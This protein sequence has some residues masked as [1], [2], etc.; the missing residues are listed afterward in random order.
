[1]DVPDVRGEGEH[2]VKHDAKDLGG[3]VERGRGA[4][5]RDLWVGTVLV[6]PGG[7]EGDV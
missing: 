4:D 6:G 5:N 3:L 1:M 2:G 7:E